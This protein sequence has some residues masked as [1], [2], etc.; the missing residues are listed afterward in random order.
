MFSWI[1]E[2]LYT[3]FQY[4][5]A[6]NAPNNGVNIKKY[7]EEKPP[8]VKIITSKEIIETLEHL[9]PTPTID[10]PVVYTS[11]LMA[12][13]NQVFDMGYKNYFEKKKSKHF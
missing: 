2:W 12:E 6:R 1:V 4:N 5:A 3:P 10:R 7:I 11:P 13:F 9:K 8:E